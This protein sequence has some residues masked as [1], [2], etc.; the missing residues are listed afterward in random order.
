MLW[1]HFG[2]DGEADIQGR[3]TER[4]LLRDVLI[5]PGTGGLYSTT[6]PL[7]STTPLSTSMTRG[8]PPQ[9]RAEHA[10]VAEHATLE[11]EEAGHGHPHGGLPHGHLPHGAPPHGAAPCPLTIAAL[12][13][14]A[15]GVGAHARART[16][17]AARASPRAKFL[18]CHPPTKMAADVGVPPLAGC[19]VLV[20]AQA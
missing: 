19:I 2:E 10:R 8:A 16:T 9:P 11:Q 17:R 5:E 7:A 6:T 15:L 4:V 3:A 14:L 1:Q 13:L 12:F 20:Q 18:C